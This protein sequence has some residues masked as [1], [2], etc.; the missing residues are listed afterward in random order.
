MPELPG[1]LKVGGLT[2]TVRIGMAEDVLEARRRRAETDFGKQQIDIS[3][4]VI[5]TLQRGSLLHEALHCLTWTAD[6]DREWGDKEE[7]YVTRLEALI[8]ML[9]VDNPDF[10]RLF[11]PE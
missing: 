2:F 4:K 10:V 5:R 1:I 6:L 9:L 7:G 3:D 11:L 8:T